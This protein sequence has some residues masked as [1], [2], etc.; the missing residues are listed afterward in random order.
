MTWP[1]MVFLPLVMTAP[2]LWHSPRTASRSGSLL[3][4]YSTSS[5]MGRMRRPAGRPFHAL[6]VSPGQMTARFSPM[7]RRPFIIWFLRPSPKDR[8]RRMATV[9][10]AMAATVRTARFFWSC[11]A[12]TK[13]WKISFMRMGA[14]HVEW[15]MCGCRN[16]ILEDCTVCS[17]ILSPSADIRHST[18]PR[19]TASSRRRGRAGWR[20]ARG[21]SRPGAP[22][23]PGRWRSARRRRETP[24]ACPR[25]PRGS[26]GRRRRSRRR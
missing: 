19:L 17:N 1:V 20:P 8:R 14:L 24:R 13:S 12:R 10:Q 11:E 25:T 7:P 15:R 6:E 4:R 18:S 23:G 21:S 22:R 2:Q 26:R 3:R 5:A 16:G 9:P